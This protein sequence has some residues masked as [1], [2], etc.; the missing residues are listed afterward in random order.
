MKDIFFYLY[1]WTPKNS[2]T[3]LY[4][5]LIP[6]YFQIFNYRL[7]RCRRLIENAFG[8]LTNTWRIFSRRIDLEPEK[9]K[10][11]ILACCSLHNMLR[12]SRVPPRGAPPANQQPHYEPPIQE[13]ERNL[14]PLAMRPSVE[15]MDIRDNFCSYFN[16]VGAV[17]WQD[18]MI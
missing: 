13:T 8:I 14:E 12:T 17:E 11:I 15:A 7:S 2:E 5:H 18:N 16:G 10:K 4:V 9:V 6:L 1:W 3:I